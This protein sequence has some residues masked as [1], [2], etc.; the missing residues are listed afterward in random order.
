MNETNWMR[1]CLVGLLAVGC[2]GMTTG[3]GGGD[4]DNDAPP[5]TVITVTNTVGGVTV[6]NTVVVTNTPPPVETDDGPFIMP[7][8]V[9]LTN[10]LAFRLT[11]PKLVWPQNEASVPALG[12]FTSVMM[13]W[14]AVPGAATYFIEVDKTKYPTDVLYRTVGLKLGQHTWRVWAQSAGKVDGWSSAPFAFTLVA[15]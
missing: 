11:A 4:D 15:Q 1:W 9:K 7:P 8:L 3:C 14:E 12:T 13:K 6:T 2:A 5:T 10:A